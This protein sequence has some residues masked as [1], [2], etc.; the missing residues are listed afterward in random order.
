MT[1]LDSKKRQLKLPTVPHIKTYA[2]LKEA[3][4]NK[5]KEVI[6]TEEINRIVGVMLHLSYWLV[7]GHVNPVQPDEL[8]RQQMI[9]ASM[10]QMNLL[11]KRVKNTKVW[12]LFVMPMILLVIRMNVEFFLRNSYYSFFDNEDDATACDIALEKVNFLITNMFDPNQ[13][14]SRFTFF[15]SEIG[16]INKK[17]NEHLQENKILHKRLYG[18]N[19]YL[20]L[21]FPNPESDFVRSMLNKKH[22]PRELQK[23]HQEREEEQVDQETGDPKQSRKYIQQTYQVKMFQLLLDKVDDDLPIQ[24]KKKHN[25]LN[26]NKIEN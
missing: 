20:D 26:F 5:T 1:T 14:Y 22:S 16:A 9:I 10:E 11:R 2:Y 21:F 25:P 23:P 18:T 15:E 13:F 3:D 12:S 8:T 19:P 7:F 4:I 6:K 17:H 24:Y